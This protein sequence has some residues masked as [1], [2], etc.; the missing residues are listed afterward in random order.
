MKQMCGRGKFF[1]AP[2][3]SPNGKLRKFDD[4]RL[5]FYEGGPYGPPYGPPFS[6]TDFGFTSANRP[7]FSSSG[8]KQF[9]ILK[10][11]RL[12]TNVNIYQ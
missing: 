11:K 3:L 2:G 5:F 4:S 10:Y 7:P 12:I 8:E 6:S 1:M 9:S